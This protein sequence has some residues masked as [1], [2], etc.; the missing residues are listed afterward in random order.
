MGI[1]HSFSDISNEI[2]KITM[3]C[4]PKICNDK[5]FMPATVFK[6]PESYKEG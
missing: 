4:I 6:L 3:S 5:F 2:I 1:F